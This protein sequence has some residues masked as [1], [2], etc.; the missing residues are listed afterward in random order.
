[1]TAGTPRITALTPAQ[2][3]KVLSAAGGGRI[4]EEMLRADIDAGAAERCPMGRSVLYRTTRRQARRR[5]MSARWPGSYSV[6][7]TRTPRAAK[8]PAMAS[9][10]APRCLRSRAPS[11]SDF[12]PK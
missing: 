4:T 10:T 11:F 3:S 1:M 8:R 12:T 5:S 7:I 2:A 9:L 6:A